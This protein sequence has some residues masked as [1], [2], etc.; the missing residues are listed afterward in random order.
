MEDLWAF[1]EEIVA[2][3]IDTST[4]PIISAVGHEIDF[5]IA[6]FVADLRAPTPSAAAELL[7]R[8]RLELLEVIRNICYTMRVNLEDRVTSE[9]ERVHHLVSSYSF[10]RPRDLV[11]ERTQR[12]DELD[13][14]VTVTFTHLFQL[15]YRRHQTALHRLEALSPKGVMKRGYAMVR[16]E[17]N[18]VTSARALHAGEKTT[19][20]F[21]DGDVATRV[22]Q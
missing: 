8:D 2:R 15:A 13:R 7:V 10:N 14:T 6:D 12:V 22:E 3:A 5:S 21:H 1:N 11:R 18:I 9:R 17:G 20:Q 16:K 4:I 19:I